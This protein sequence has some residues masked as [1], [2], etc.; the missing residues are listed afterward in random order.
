MIEDV[1]LDV[2]SPLTSFQEE[3]LH[4]CGV[5]LDDINV[6]FMVE[7][8][9]A[10]HITIIKAVE[11]AA[12]LFVLGMVIRLI[13]IEAVVALTNFHISFQTCDLRE[14][15]IHRMKGGLSLEVGEIAHLS[16]LHNN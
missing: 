5:H 9:P 3:H 6:A 11:F 14:G 12:F 10:S 2:S 4:T 16:F 13:V 8:S 7:C 15:Q 1:G